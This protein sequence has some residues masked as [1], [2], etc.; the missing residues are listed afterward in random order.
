MDAINDAFKYGPLSSQEVY[1]LMQHMDVRYSI[2]R[3]HQQP[4]FW[5]NSPN[6]SHLILFWYSTSITIST[7]IFTH[8]EDFGNVFK[9]YNKYI[10]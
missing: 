7:L 6:V 5:R 4:V 10:F 9:C 3:R 8:F 1:V 2:N